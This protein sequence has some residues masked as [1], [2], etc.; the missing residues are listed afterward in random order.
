M[1]RLLL[2]IASVGCAVGSLWMSGTSG[3]VLVG[4]AC[5]LGIMARLNQAADH[6]EYLKVKAMVDES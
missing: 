5:W 2:L 4:L 1:F 3:T 6:H